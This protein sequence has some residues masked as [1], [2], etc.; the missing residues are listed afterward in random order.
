M[1][2]AR[3]ANPFMLIVNPQA[4]LDAIERSERL[5]RLQRRVCHPL[6]KLVMPTTLA[7]A[8]SARE[9]ELDEE[10]EAETPA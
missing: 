3:P 10:A 5:E 2:T 7:G 4:V 1:P 6:D 9:P 8:E